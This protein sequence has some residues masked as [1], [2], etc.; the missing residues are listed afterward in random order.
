MKIS[1]RTPII[2]MVL[3]FLIISI[4][5]SLTAQ[6]NSI[7]AVLDSASLEAQLNDLNERTR[8]YNDFRAIREDVFQKMKKNVID[9][10]NM[11]KLEVAR[12]NSELI[13]RDFQIEILN[14]DLS[15]AKTERDQSIRTKDSFA[16]LGMQ[17]QKGVYNTVMWIIVVGLLILGVILFLMFKRSFV[18]T[19]QTKNEL[20]AILEEFEEYR[21]S[22]REKYEKLVVSHHSEIMKM[23]RS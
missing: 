12:L 20:E 1:C 15:R 18:V 19:S 13:E 22:S 8:V 2:S 21:K 9:T 6:S 17:V 23:K 3:A 10:L 5:P 14:T 7:I 16:F 4:S 11:E